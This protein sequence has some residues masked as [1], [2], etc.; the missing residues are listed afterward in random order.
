MI[1]SLGKTAEQIQ[2][3]T[4]FTL[5]LMGLLSG[6]FWPAWL[7]PDAMQ[8]LS[9][10][11]PHAW[12]LRAYQDILLRDSTLLATLPNILVLLTFGA[13]FYLLALSRFKYE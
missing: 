9:R 8:K 10:I 4:T 11:T 6:C 3:M 5:L 12:A 2:G 13:V 7:M 1:A